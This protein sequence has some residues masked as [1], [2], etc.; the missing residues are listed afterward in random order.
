VEKEHIT[1]YKMTRA[2]FIQ[3]LKV[4]KK[5]ADKTGY[6]MLFCQVLLLVLVVFVCKYSD[7]FPKTWQPLVML[8]NLV[9]GF[10]G[11]VAVFGSHAKKFRKH[12]G[13]CCPNCR[14][15]LIGG[16]AQVVVASDRCGFCGEIILEDWN[17]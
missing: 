12:F 13:L 6:L 11:I 14:K 3:K 10:F 9:G 8:A 5:Q 2:E 17:K 16:S 4:W 7:S 1:K 15:D